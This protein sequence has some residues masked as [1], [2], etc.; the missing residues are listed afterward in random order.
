MDIRTVLYAIRHRAAGYLRGMAL[1]ALATWVVLMIGLYL[2]RVPYWGLI[3]F[4]ITLVDLVP[5][6]GAGIVLVPWG[7][8]ALLSGEARLAL[9][10]GILFG[11]CFLIQEVLVPLWIGKSVSLHPLAS[12]GILVAATVLFGPWGALIG[13]VATVILSVYR[14]MRAERVAGKKIPR[15]E[16]EDSVRSQGEGKDQ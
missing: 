8:I 15:E 2:L 4:G 13:P 16:E 6:I 9:G 10:L 3:A 12:L 7:F 14:D 5:V 1:G 11:L